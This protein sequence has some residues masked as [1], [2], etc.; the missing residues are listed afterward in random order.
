MAREDFTRDNDGYS[1]DNIYPGKST[2]D[3]G[4]S[5][6]LRVPI[7]THWQAIMMTYVSSPEWPEYRSLQD[8]ARDAIYHRWNWA[9]DWERRNGRPLTPE[10]KQLMAMAAGQSRAEQSRLVDERFIEY[11]DAQ[12]EAMRLKY[13]RQDFSALMEIIEELEVAAED[14]M[15]KDRLRVLEMADTWRRK[16]ERYL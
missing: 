9:K 5:F 7:P 10:L 13:N 12:E 8:F 4:H 2:D 16:V 1:V 6:H 11:M 3:K 15:E 14:F